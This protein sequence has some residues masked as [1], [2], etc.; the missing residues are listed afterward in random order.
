MGTETDNPAE[1]VQTDCALFM[2]RDPTDAG[3]LVRLARVALWLCECQNLSRKAAVARLCDTVEAIGHRPALFRVQAGEEAQPADDYGVAP[4]K[5]PQ[6]RY[7]VV[8]PFDDWSFERRDGGDGFHTPS[9][10]N[11]LGMLRDSERVNLANHARQ[12]PEENAPRPDPGWP[13]AL[14]GIRKQWASDHWWNR[15][16]MTPREIFGDRRLFGRDLA[17]TVADAGAV[18]EWGLTP[19]ATFTTPEQVIAFRLAHPNSRWVP[20]HLRIIHDA[21]Q[22]LGGQGKAGAVAAIAARLGISP[23]RLNRLLGGIV[24]QADSIL[25]VVGGGYGNDPFGRTKGQR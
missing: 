24:P 8:Q 20:E 19:G 9:P 15:G 7:R 1:W 17:V 21:V 23:R 4:V 22:R 3:R 2:R 13:Y 25:H 16:P 12:A 10:Y 14:H 18:W 6:P 11:A 5:P